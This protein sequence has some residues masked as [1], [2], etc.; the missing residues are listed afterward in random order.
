MQGLEVER[1]P[2]SLAQELLASNKAFFEEHRHYSTPVVAIDDMARIEGNWRLPGNREA[3]LQASLE[4]I[5]SSKGPIEIFS[6]GSSWVRELQVG[7]LHASFAHRPIRILCEQED[8]TDSNFAKSRGAAIASGASVAVTKSPIGIRGTMVSSNT[9]AATLISIERRPTL[10]GLKLSSPHEN[11]VLGAL[12]TLFDQQW[13]TA[14]PSPAQAPEIRSM[15]VEYVA[16]VLKNAIPAYRDAKFHV[17]DIP[18]NS[19][20]LLSR[21]MERFKLFRIAVLEDVL[22]K[23][24]LPKM[25]EIVGSPWPYLLPLVE[26]DSSG[27]Y[28]VI[29]GAHRVFHAM[30]KHASSIQAI[31]IDGVSLPLPSRPIENLDEI[32]VTSDKWRRID[33]YIDFNP[34]YFRNIRDALEGDL[35]RPAEIQN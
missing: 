23:Q 16:G 15:T 4:L 20:R 25:G 11:G 21:S 7:L 1:F 28:T 27:K 13:R 2:F 19:L 34:E 30:Q 14:K 24:N 12:S 33:R 17:E 18:V 32:K 35:W 8:E 26:R 9:E 6:G 3:I 5:I 10:H 29:D 31:C 22:E